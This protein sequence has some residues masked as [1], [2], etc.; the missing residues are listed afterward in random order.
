MRALTT[1]FCFL[2]AVY[3]VFILIHPSDLGKENK[4]WENPNTDLQMPHS[5]NSSIRDLLLFIEVI[6]QRQI[7]CTLSFPIHPPLISISIS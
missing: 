7:S 1:M 4:K 2:V 3:S 6:G 5:S